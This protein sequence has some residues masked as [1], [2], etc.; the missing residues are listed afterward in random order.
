[1]H[2]VTRHLLEADERGD[3][4]LS[5]VQRFFVSQVHAKTGYMVRQQQVSDEERRWLV[6]IAQLLMV[7][8]F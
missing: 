7:S 8:V 1:V 6:R 2:R 5:G 4:E 3:V